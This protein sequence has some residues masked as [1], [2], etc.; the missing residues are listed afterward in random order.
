MLL[1]IQEDTGQQPQALQSRPSVTVS[2][3]FY[4]DVFTRI[5]RCRQFSMSG[6]MPLAV[7]QALLGYCEYYG[8]HDV[9]QRESLATAITAL[10]T[11]YM[12]DATKRT[13]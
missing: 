4:M 8:I 13:T 2:E 6:P 1:E 3:K 7:E 5:S 12:E 11:A 10:D 9:E